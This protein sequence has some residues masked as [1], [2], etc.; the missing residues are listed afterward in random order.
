MTDDASWD[1]TVKRLAS[2]VEEH[3]ADHPEAG[4]FLAYRRGELAGAERE[5]FEEHLAWCRD[6]AAMARDLP[7]LLEGDAEPFDPEEKAADW[8][9]IEE[10]LEREPVTR[11]P[12]GEAEPREVMGS[13]KRSLLTAGLAAAL[14]LA[15]GGAGVW[16]SLL[17][18]RLGELGKPRVNVPSFDLLPP[19]SER[20]GEE[21]PL[22]LDLERGAYLILDSRVD[23][24]ERTYEARILDERGRE[25]WRLEGLR[26][27]RFGNLSLEL[28]PEY[29]PPGV[30]RIVLQGE[31]GG[32]PVAKY[33]LRVAPP[34]S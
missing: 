12:G 25:L 4:A 7:E 31:G 22:T 20:A 15:V 17:Y 9:A 34:G 6:C 32:P 23:L 10:R 13:A 30:Y 19:G 3:L 26:A 29:L 24:G 28:P 11:A 5:A 2:A 33:A 16:I 14:I 8:A 18:G 1:D 21:A 27:T